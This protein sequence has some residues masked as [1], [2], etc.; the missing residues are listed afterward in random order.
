MAAVNS[1]PPADRSVL[2]T[3]VLSV[4][5]TGVLNLAP[6]DAAIAEAEHVLEQAR[7]FGLWDS[8]EITRQE[9]AANVLPI[10]ALLFVIA[11]DSDQPAIETRYR[12]IER[13]LALASTQM[14]ARQTVI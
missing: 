11:D 10:T 8:L 14:E 12:R 13:L 9:L 6:L 2:E 3:R 7:A 5:T 1:V 4:T